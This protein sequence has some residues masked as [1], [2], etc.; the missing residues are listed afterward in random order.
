MQ[1]GQASHAGGR[2]LMQGAGRPH[3]GGGA[4]KQGKVSQHGPNNFSFHKGDES[5]IKVHIANIISLPF[6]VS[7]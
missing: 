6:N 2:G 1:Q 3:A 5:M 7:S 4:T